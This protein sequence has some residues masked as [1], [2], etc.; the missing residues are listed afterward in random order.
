M[1][2]KSDTH[3]YSINTTNGLR[4]KSIYSFYHFSN[5]R[6]H[7]ATWCNLVQL[8]TTWC[9]L[10]IALRVVRCPPELQDGVKIT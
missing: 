6:T 2:H 9:R 8:N 4:E 5:L 10:W 1:M 3:W 7:Y